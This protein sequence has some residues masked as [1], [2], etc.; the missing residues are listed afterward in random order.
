MKRRPCLLI[1]SLLLAGGI[2]FLAG[3]YAGAPPA[4]EESKSG[5]AL[6]KPPPAT[7]SNTGN[8]TPAANAASERF[9]ALHLRIVG[10][11]PEAFG[12]RF[13]ELLTSHNTPDT[14]LERAAMI[15]SVDPER[16]TAA[17]LAFKKR[18]GASFRT[19]N[20]EVAD[21]LIMGAQRD[22]AKLMAAIQ[23]VTPDFGEVSNIAHG[24]AF[25]SPSSAVEWYNSLPDD[26]VR[27]KDALHGLVFGLGQRDAGMAR[28][29]FHSLSPEDQAISAPHMSWSLLIAQGCEGVERLIE[30][31]PP[32]IAVKCIEGACDSRYRRQPENM[33]P[34]LATHLGASGGVDRAFVANW[35]R[36]KSNDSAAAEQWRVAA[37][38]ANPRI[39]PL[40]PPDQ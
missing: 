34:W 38:A 2:G 18:S 14:L 20:P 36:W 3:K 19:Y 37:V 13:A 1:V 33:V 30:G 27:R 40:L 21:L 39:V 8:P 9:T 7:A 11:S 12:Q 23:K 10:M 32:E 5:T 26:Y 22:G 6:K 16:A 31:L 17:Y 35:G 28:T 25:A 29:V 24:W 15:A 4:G